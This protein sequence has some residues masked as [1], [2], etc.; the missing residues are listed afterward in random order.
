MYLGI[1]GGGTKTEVFLFDK[2]L[3]TRVRLQTAGSH[4]QSL[5]IEKS[6]EHI[7][8]G[9]NKALQKVKVPI[10][11]IDRAMFALS[12]ALRNKEILYLR[13]KEEYPSLELE[14]LSDAELLLEN[15]FNAS[16]KNTVLKNTFKNSSIIKNIDIENTENIEKRTRAFSKKKNCILHIAGTG[17][18]LM[19]LDSKGEIKKIGGNGHLIDDYGSAYDIAI[20]LIRRM[21]HDKEKHSFHSDPYA[22]EKKE[23]LQQIQE[24]LN[25]SSVKKWDGK[26]KKGWERGLE[27]KWTKKRSES[28]DEEWEKELVFWVYS[29]SRSE[30]AHLAN[31][32]LNIAFQQKNRF[33]LELLK[34][35]RKRLLRDIETLKEILGFTEYSL[36]LFGGLILKHP[37]YQDYLEQGMKKLKGLESIV[38]VNLEKAFQEAFKKIDRENNQP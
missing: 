22:R 28:W 21:I 27:K 3:E 2:K 33:L 19:G 5:G 24:K 23:I 17:S 14:V 34:R 37:E 36:L 30:I 29:H 10:Q 12:G 25:L 20:T 15:G 6:I 13:L 18:L 16:Y 31:W 1:D 9:I 7:R 38:T 11:S 26:G 8:E 32:I 35:K 4:W